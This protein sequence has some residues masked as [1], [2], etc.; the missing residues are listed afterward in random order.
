MKTKHHLSRLLCAQIVSIRR[1]E[2]APAK[3]QEA[4]LEE[5]GPDSAALSLQLPLKKGTEIVIECKETELRGTVEN[6]LR[7]VD[8]YMLEVGFPEGQDWNPAEFM[9]RRL[10]NPA[11]MVCDR[12]CC[13]PDCVK[14]E[15]LY[16]SDP[17]WNPEV[18]E[19]H[20]PSDTTTQ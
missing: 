19:I 14:A 16:R 10:F 20:Q 9:P 4:L 11:S 7:W 12:D 5:I 15:C 6:C 17:Q 1:S 18:A 2:T 13:R 3:P 8:G